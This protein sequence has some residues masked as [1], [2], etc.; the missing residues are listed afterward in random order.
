MQHS[1]EKMQK[2]SIDELF[3]DM[4]HPNPNIN[5]LAYYG[6][7]RDWPEESIRRLISNLAIDDISLR[8]KSITALSIFGEK[9]ID[10]LIA[11]YLGKYDNTL[12]LSCLKVFVKIAASNPEIQFPKDI[13]KVIAE[14]RLDDSVTIT[15][16]LVTFLRQLNRNGLDTLIKMANDSNIL[17]AKAAITAIAEI[18][19]PIAIKCLQDLIANESTDEFIA[20]SAQEA[21]MAINQNTKI[22]S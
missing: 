3:E 17:K 5:N 12:R 9:I 10:R 4:A 16:T 18:D 7:L 2:K 13:V 15:L 22:S 19:G 14:A 11:L 1:I 6:M 8:R 21:L 20:I